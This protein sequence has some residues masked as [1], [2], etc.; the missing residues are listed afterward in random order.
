M[1]TAIVIDDED[2]AAEVFCEY[3]RIKDVDVIGRGRNGREAVELYEELKPDVVL[4]DVVMP[5]FDGFY[6][7]EKIREFDPDAKVIMV[8]ASAVTDADKKQ[9]ESLGASAVIYKPYDIDNVIET[10][11]KVR[12]DNPII[13]S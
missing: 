11:D 8:T 13:P 2:D 3:L 6:G 7:L 5:E 12:K 9:M 10:I 4:S 1:T